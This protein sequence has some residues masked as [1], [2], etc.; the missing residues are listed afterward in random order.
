MTAEAPPAGED[1]ANPIVDPHAAPASYITHGT[2][3]GIG[4]VLLRALRAGLPV[5]ERGGDIRVLG[6]EFVLECA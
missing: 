5:W 6:G 3:S 1:D 2:V 4:A